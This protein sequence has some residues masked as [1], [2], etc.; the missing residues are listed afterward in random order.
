M[1]LKLQA[2]FAYYLTIL[3]EMPLS[4][5]TRKSYASLARQFIHFMEERE[6]SEFTA[7]S[8]G[9]FAQEF[10][11]SDY[12]GKASSINSRASAIKHFLQVSGVPCG[13][14]ERP[15]AKLTTREC[16]T[17]EELRSFLAAAR[18]FCPR[19]KAIGMLFAST[20]IRLKECVSLNLDCID[21]IDGR[22]MLELERVGGRQHIPLS[23]E[24]QSAMEEYLDVKVD[25]P[26]DGVG[27]AL[28]VD[29][30]GERLSMR[31]LT[32]SV[33]KIGWSAKLAVTPAILRVTRLTCVARGT[34]DAVSV[35]Y[36]GGF[37]SLES[38]KRILRAS[39]ND[40]TRASVQADLD[41]LHRNQSASAAAVG[42]LI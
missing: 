15:Q 8:L 35:A 18:K 16:L 14:L 33:R 1:S 21:Y 31:A 13:T 3:P 2:L 32:A 12:Y 22:M 29:K 39:K 40:L 30:N 19:D 23:A 26:S 36:L 37:G 25:C 10:L 42:F 20:G 17:E 4:D 27:H 5:S 24:A 6:V 41:R 9:A 34:N 11:S 38:A 28:F 7:A